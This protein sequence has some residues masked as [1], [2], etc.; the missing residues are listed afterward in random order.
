M[1]RNWGITLG[2]FLLL[3]PRPT[4]AQH[5]TGRPALTAFDSA[6]VH[7]LLQSRLPC[8]GCHVLD[9]KGG[10]IGPDLTSVA[11]RRSAAYIRA[12]IDDPQRVVPGSVM[13]RIPMPSAM[14]A[15]VAD[16]L[17]AGAPSTETVL[18]SGA[19]AARTSSGAALYARNCAA[20]HG[21]R[22]RG[23]GPNARYLPA[24][25]AP[26]ADSAF[27][28]ERSDDRLF[29]AIFAGGYPL[30]RSA[31]M[32][33]FGETLSRAEIRSL[34]RHLRTL[35]RCEGPAWARKLSASS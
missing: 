15:L 25:P 4:L 19:P 16:Y 9:G 24:R 17:A 23:D 1:S 2:L 14:R 20:C 26:H 18:A 10:R 28:S 29:D 11:L 32:P 21:E 13:P 22:G 8:L 6:K 31:T 34:V 27:M 33:A 30:G 7:A 12:M 3:S 35:C 5:A